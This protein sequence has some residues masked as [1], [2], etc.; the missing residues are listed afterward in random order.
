MQ[1]DLVVVILHDS[2]HNQYKIVKIVNIVNYQCW[3]QFCLH[4]YTVV[5]G[6]MV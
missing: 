1:R 5:G 3:E 4:L 2:I 6:C